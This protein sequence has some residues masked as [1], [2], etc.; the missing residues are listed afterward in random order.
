DSSSSFTCFRYSSRLERI[1]SSLIAAFLSTYDSLARNPGRSLS[2]GAPGN[3]G[4]WGSQS[5]L[6][7]SQSPKLTSTPARLLTRIGV[8]GCTITVGQGLRLRVSSPQ[9]MKESSMQAKRRVAILLGVVILSCGL[10]Y[11]QTVSGIINGS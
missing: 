3:D 5:W 7:T 2:R 6:P 10:A 9:A 4:T 1:G 11:S 8:I